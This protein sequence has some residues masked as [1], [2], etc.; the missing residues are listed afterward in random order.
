MCAAAVSDPVQEMLKA[1]ARYPLLT[2]LQEVELG[3]AIRAW[4]D[5]PDGPDQA[6]PRIQKAGK[7]ALDR[8]VVCNIRLAH[9]LAKRYSNRGVPIEDLMQASIEGMITAY[10]K[11]KPELGYR[12]SSYAIW[13]A[14]QACQQLVACMGQTLRLPVHTCDAMGQVLKASRTFYE[15]HGRTPSS[16]ELAAGAR[17]SEEQLNRL[18]ELVARSRMVS[19]DAQGKS[20]HIHT[21]VRFSGEFVEQQGQRMTP[22]NGTTTPCADAVDSLHQ[23]QV[24]IELRDC[25]ERHPQITDQQRFILRQ[26]HLEPEP[27]NIV[28]LAYLLHMNRNT[29]LALEQQALEILRDSIGIQACDAVAA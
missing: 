28:R 10:R 27:P 22:A 15:A 18:N 6:P 7:R 12:S 26:L 13:Y 8:F 19:I 25:L 23:Q 4:Q 2:P 11:F 17:M 5:H 14:R 9:H 20:G 1:A 29:L 3:R 16:A 21:H 24:A